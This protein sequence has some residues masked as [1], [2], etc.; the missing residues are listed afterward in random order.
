MSFFSSTGLGTPLCRRHTDPLGTG[1][2]VR[3]GTKMTGSNTGPYE[4]DPT[5]GDSDTR[6]LTRTD[7]P[8]HRFPVSL[9]NDFPSSPRMDR[10]LVSDLGGPFEEGPLTSEK[11]SLGGSGHDPPRGTSPPPGFRFNRRRP[12]IVS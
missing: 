3:D 11:S 12:G 4:G 2:D 8:M 10:D 5:P 6:L 1:V 7:V 9:R